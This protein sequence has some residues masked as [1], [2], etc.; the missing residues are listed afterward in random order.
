MHIEPDALSELESEVTTPALPADFFPQAVE[1]H[2]VQRG[3][4]LTPQSLVDASRLQRVI[5]P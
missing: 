2:D 5:E 3:I 1:L 4:G